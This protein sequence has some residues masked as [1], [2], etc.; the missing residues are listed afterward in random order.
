[1][2]AIGRS[3]LADDPRLA[4]NDGRVEHTEMLDRAIADWTSQHDLDHVLQVL[5]KAGWTAPV[6]PEPEPK[7][8]S[9][10]QTGSR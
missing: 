7:D 9:T 6:V 8:A 10:S 2:L 5:E 4:R 3:D 1:M